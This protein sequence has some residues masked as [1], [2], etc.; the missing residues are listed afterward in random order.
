MILG[1]LNNPLTKL[2]VGKVT[3]H[4]KHKAE[5]VKTIRAAEIEAANSGKLVPI[6]IIVRP[7]TASGIPRPTAK[8]TPPSTV[9]SE[10]TANK[11]KL[12]IIKKEA[13]V[14]DSSL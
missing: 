12:K 7:I 9:N 11:I 5:K 8:S 6:A 4:F 10:L 1:L 14:I 3:D 13:L 2:A